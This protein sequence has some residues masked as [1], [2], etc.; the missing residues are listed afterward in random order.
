MYFDEN[1]IRRVVSNLISNAFKYSPEG[2]SV[3]VRLSSQAGQ[4]KLECMDTGPGIPSQEI[5]FI[6]NR[7]Y[8]V[9][10]QQQGSGIGLYLVKEYVRLHGG[11]ISVESEP[12]S[13]VFTVNIPTTLSPKSADIVFNVSQVDTTYEQQDT[14][15]KEPVSTAIEKPQTIYELKNDD[16]TLLVVE[17][18]EAL[19][20]FMV[21]ELQ[22]TYKVVEAA[23]GIDGL[24]KARSCVPDLII[25]DVMMP[26]M[27][28]YEMCKQLKFE[29]TTS[30]IPVVLL[31]AKATEEHRFEG[32][33]A[34]ADEY[35]SKPFN[36]DFLALRVE[37]LLKQ[38]QLRKEQFKSNRDINPAAITISSL[39]EQ[40]LQ[41]AL[42][43]V[44]R[45]MAN[46]EYTV[47]QLSKEMNMDRTV[48]Y[49]K[50]HSITGLTPSEFIRTLR[51]KR[52]AQL[53]EQGNYPVAEV[54]EMV[55]FKTQRYFS[56]YFK[57]TFGILPSHY[58]SRK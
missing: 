21:S 55:G 53:L 9:T 45:N 38:Q 4:V 15:L 36:L 37:Q 58:R 2:G 13:T 46:T 26:K 33:K 50:V 30:H 24:S 32:Y 6:F 42:E 12:G 27:D 39:D 5:P 28:G 25:S 20:H 51:L 23:D 1:K 29:L 14:L 35:I 48:L 52:A 44:E 43:C 31:T 54:S 22:K 16:Y 34:G 47:F 17:D 3:R 18:N 41:K 40:L 49:K 19:R 57:S 56:N 8:R 10:D 7:F 11:F